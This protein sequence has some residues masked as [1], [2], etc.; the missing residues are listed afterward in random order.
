M[1]VWPT[2]TWDGRLYTGQLV[3]LCG[4]WVS[5][6]V[7]AMFVGCFL[8]WLVGC[9]VGLLG[10]LVWVGQAQRIVGCVLVGWSACWLV[11]WLVGCLFI[12]TSS[13]IYIE[14]T[15]IDYIR[16]T[17][18]SGGLNVPSLS[19]TYNAKLAAR[20]RPLIPFF[21]FKWGACRTKAISEKILSLRERL[22]PVC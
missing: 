15:F 9:L 1:L 16:V 8:V 5:L 10:S 4:V 21:L 12:Y 19:N 6:V 11:C 17:H 14:S 22:H 7:L 13:Y 20:F 3:L 2:R 18:A